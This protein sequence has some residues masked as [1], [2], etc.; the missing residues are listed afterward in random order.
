M[1]EQSK[2]KLNLKLFIFICCFVFI[3]KNF[4]RINN[5]IDLNYNQWPDIY[6]EE[7][8]NEIN[9]FELIKQNN[10]LLFYFS[11]GRLCMYSKSPCSNFKTENLKKESFFRYNLYFTN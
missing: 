5:N 11:N 4:L 9:N 8:T 7:N 1:P 6:S 3:T 2:L 10:D